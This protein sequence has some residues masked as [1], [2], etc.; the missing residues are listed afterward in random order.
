MLLGKVIKPINLTLTNHLPHAVNGLAQVQCK[1]DIYRPTD[2]QLTSQPASFCVLL[3]LSLAL[4]RDIIYALFY[5]NSGCQFAVATTAP[6]FPLIG[7]LFCTIQFPPVTHL[8]RSLV[9]QAASHATRG[10]LI[11]WRVCH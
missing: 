9:C 6:T 2:R 5:T 4:C 3:S 1:Y 8:V 7:C 10:S 11:Q